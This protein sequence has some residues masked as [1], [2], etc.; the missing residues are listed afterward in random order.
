MMTD[1]LFD[2]SFIDSKT[3]EKLLEIIDFWRGSLQT[4]FCA[5]ECVDGYLISRVYLEYRNSKADV[6]KDFLLDRRKR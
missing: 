2:L 4:P 5:R 1:T 6:K 3:T